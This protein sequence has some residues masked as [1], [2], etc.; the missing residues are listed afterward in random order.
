MLYFLHGNSKVALALP[1][2]AI[3]YQGRPSVVPGLPGQ[4]VDGLGLH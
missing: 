2:A 1:T 4:G 3:R